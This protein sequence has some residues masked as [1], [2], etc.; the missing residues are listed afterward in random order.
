MQTGA[1]GWRRSDA[2]RH[3]T[4]CHATDRLAPIPPSAVAAPSPVA[5]PARP[6]HGHWLAN[7]SAPVTSA[8]RRKNGHSPAAPAPVAASPE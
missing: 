1:S 4:L 8:Q 2:K 5:Q 6:Q 3:Q 7:I